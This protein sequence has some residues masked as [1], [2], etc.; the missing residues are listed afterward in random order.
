MR[1]LTVKFVLLVG[2][3]VTGGGIVAIA[4]GDADGDGE[5]ES[6][7]R[8]QRGVREPTDAVR[9]EQAHYRLLY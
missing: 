6:E 8:G 9:A 2:P 3:G 5:G 1:S 4:V 7:L